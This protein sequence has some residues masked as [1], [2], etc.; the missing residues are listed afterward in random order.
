MSIEEEYAFLKLQAG[1]YV[2]IKEKVKGK[3]VRIIHTD[4]TDQWG[5]PLP[6]AE[7]NIIDDQHIIIPLEELER[8]R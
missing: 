1:D 4:A 3:I 5:M 8:Q 2:Q 7:V 6:N